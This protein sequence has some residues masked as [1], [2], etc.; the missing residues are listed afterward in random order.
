MGT[1]SHGEG[2]TVLFTG[3]LQA[4]EAW[5]ITWEDAHRSTL[6]PSLPDLTSGKHVPEWTPGEVIPSGKYDMEREQGSDMPGAQRVVDF[7][8]IGAPIL[9]VAVVA[10]CIWLCVRHGKNKKKRKRLEIEKR[11]GGSS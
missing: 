6:T 2:S 8:M 10:P 5:H 1:L 4:H 3:G 7:A 11:V 9:G